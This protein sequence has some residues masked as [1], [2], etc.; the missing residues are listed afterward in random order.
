[1]KVLFVSS[2]NTKE[3]ISPIINNQGHSLK[4]QGIVVDFFTVKGKGFWSYFRHIF[5][6]SDY[7]RTKEFDIIHAHYGL[8]GL[9]ALFAKNHDVKLIV[10][11]MGNDLLGDHSKNGNAGISGKLRV[12]INQIC[13]KYFDYIIVKSHE[14]ENKISFGNKTVIPNG[15]DMI[16]FVPIDKQQ[17]IA[18]IGWDQHC[19]HVLFLSSPDRP[20]KNF[21]LA[22]I[23]FRNMK[24]DGVLLHILKDIP[25]HDLVLYYN[26]SD[27]CIL[28]SFHEGSPNTI[29]EAMAC[30]RPVIS[31]DV[32]DVREVF[33]DIEGCYI[34]SFDPADVTEKIRLALD[35]GLT[36]DRTDGRDRIID[37]GLDSETIAGK[38]IAL[39]DKVLNTAS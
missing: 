3:G 16:Q 18:K 26:A 7:L 15:I 32:G 37:L 25:H 4:K 31:T 21:R 33:G 24:T 2:G 35:F 11:F 22:E 36:K 28:T 29:K 14:M 5:I 19:R 20:E 12:C 10:S 6:L 17:A 23:A 1:M 8:C 30:N 27:V 38:L 13:A 39:Y 9:V 34:S